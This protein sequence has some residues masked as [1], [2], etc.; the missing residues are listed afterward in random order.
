MEKTR[1]TEAKH[2]FIAS[3]EAIDPV[4]LL[5]KHPL[6]SVGVA[7]LLGAMIGYS[8]V[9]AKNMWAL[10]NTG[11]L[12]SHKIISSSLE[13]SRKLDERRKEE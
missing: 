5:R 13:T 4:R 6:P 8:K 1:L 10:L 9:T 12:L 3:A 2:K 7:G 11:L